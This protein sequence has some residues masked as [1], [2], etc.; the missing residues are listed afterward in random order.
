MDR[1]IH[2]TRCDCHLVPFSI[3]NGRTEL[4]CPICDTPTEVVSPSVVPGIIAPHTFP[5]HAKVDMPAAT[6]DRI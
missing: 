5:G 4:Q 2:C 3:I 1:M 6:P